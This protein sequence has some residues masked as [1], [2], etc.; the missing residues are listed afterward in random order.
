MRTS[1]TYDTGLHRGLSS[2]MAGGEF[3]DGLCNGLIC[4]GLNHALHWVADVGDGIT[5]YLKDYEKLE[6]MMGKQWDQMISMKLCK[7]YCLEAIGKYLGYTKTRGDYMDIG[8][9]LIHNNEDAFLSALIM[10]SG[11]AGV[12]VYGE[13]FDNSGI[14]TANL[15]AGNP[16]MLTLNTGGEDLHSVVLTGYRETNSGAIEYHLSNPDFLD[17]SGWVNKN[18][19]SIKG[20]YIFTNP[21]NLIR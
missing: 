21:D 11:F 5:T 13:N 14:I 4:A 16:I 8:K 20:Y 2:S 3:W 18:T 10:E 17:R 6:M 12:D 19:L 15:N 9:G 1:T 7:Y